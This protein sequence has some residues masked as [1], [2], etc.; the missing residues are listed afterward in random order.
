MNI[1]TN[2]QWH[3]K[4]GM[5]HLEVFSLHHPS[6]HATLIYKLPVHFKLP[7]RKLYGNYVQVKQ[8]TQ[9]LECQLSLD[10]SDSIDQIRNPSVIMHSSSAW[11]PS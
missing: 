9:I 4:D 1:I 7:G 2:G 10:V 8:L 5:I 11:F 6:C 3:T